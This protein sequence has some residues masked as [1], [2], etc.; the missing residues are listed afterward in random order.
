LRNSLIRE[1]IRLPG[2]PLWM[3]AL[4]HTMVRRAC[5]LA[6]TEHAKAVT[7]ANVPGAFVECGVAEGGSALLLAKLRTQL[8][9]S[10]E[11][12]LFDTFEGLPPPSSDDAD[13]DTAV[14]WIGLCRGELADIQRLMTRHNE[15][16]VRYVKGLYQETMPAGPLP[17]SI[18]V[19]HL[20]ADWYDSTMT[21]L[22]HL[23][24]RVSPG[25]RVQFDDYGAWAGCFKAVQ[26]FFGPQAHIHQIEPK[27]AIWIEKTS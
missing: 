6:L 14:Q 25:G 20:D 5:L 9:P 17:A 22:R 24:P 10:R 1:L 23:W 2:M 26:E 27:G 8:D 7:R 21:C 16:R 11:V 13:Y 19:L 4:P 3:K 15:P 18:A 12:W